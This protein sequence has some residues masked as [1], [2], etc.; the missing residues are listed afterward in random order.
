VEPTQANYQNAYRSKTHTQLFDGLRFIHKALES[1]DFHFKWPDLRIRYVL[2]I[3][4]HAYRMEKW[5]G[6]FSLLYIKNAQ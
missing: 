6:K 4:L 3:R 5:Q 1:S 2:Y